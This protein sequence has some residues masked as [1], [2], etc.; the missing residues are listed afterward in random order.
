MVVRANFHEIGVRWIDSLASVEYWVSTVGNLRDFES[1]SP[2][3]SVGFSSDG[4]YLAIGGEDHNVDIVSL[5]FLPAV[6]LA[7]PE[8]YSDFMFTAIPGSR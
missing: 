3:R 2:I 6:S 8:Q 1:R 5:C 7:D 4:E